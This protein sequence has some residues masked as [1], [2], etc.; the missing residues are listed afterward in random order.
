MSRYLFDKE[1]SVPERVGDYLY[2]TRMGSGDNYPIFCRRKDMTH[3]EEV[4]LDN[5]RLWK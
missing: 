1:R 2:Y 3:P 5:V 4:L